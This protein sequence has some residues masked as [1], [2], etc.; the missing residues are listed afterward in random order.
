MIG[1]STGHTSSRTKD[2]ADFFALSEY[3]Q[4]RIDL[5]DAV[6]SAIRQKPADGDDRLREVFELLDR[7]VALQLEALGIDPEKHLVR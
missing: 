3:E 2:E 5:G 1:K 6:R 4:L 7:R